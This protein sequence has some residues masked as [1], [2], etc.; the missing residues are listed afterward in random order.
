M[1]HDGAPPRPPSRGTWTPR[2]SQ[3]IAPGDVTIVFCKPGP[4]QM[5][6]L[7]PAVPRPP[8]YLDSPTPSIAAS[9]SILSFGSEV[10]NANLAS[11]ATRRRGGLVRSRR[12]VDIPPVVPSYAMCN[13]L[14][15]KWERV[16]A[17]GDLM[18][19]L[20][21]SVGG[22]WDVDVEMLW[23]V[24][25]GGAAELPPSVTRGPQRPGAG[26]ALG[27]QLQ[28]FACSPRSLA[29]KSATRVLP[30]PLCPFWAH[31]AR[32]LS[33]WTNCGSGTSFLSEKGRVDRGPRVGP[34]ECHM[35]HQNR[36]WGSKR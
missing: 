12:E 10:R 20:F 7:T 27:W 24:G 31:S 25:A 34:K 2:P 11:L 29:Q 14:R 36:L 1:R 32:G 18:K 16:S 19:T 23:C 5:A 26:G 4:Y 15:T 9:T 33:L 8:H 21:A 17:F 35:D 3:L 28:I 6:C 13:T 30:P 22:K